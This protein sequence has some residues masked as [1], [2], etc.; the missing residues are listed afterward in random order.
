MILSNGLDYATVGQDRTRMKIP[1]LRYRLNERVETIGKAKLVQVMRELEPDK[2]KKCLEQAYDSITRA[3][4]GLLNAYARDLPRGTHLRIRL[5]DCVSINL[6]WMTGK[7]GAYAPYP[8]L[9]VRPGNALRS[10]L[11]ALRI[12]AYKQWKA[13]NK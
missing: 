2:E 13:A 12:A 3:L 9:W 5:N 7:P 1:K 4:N 10:R 11:E 6:C 8:N